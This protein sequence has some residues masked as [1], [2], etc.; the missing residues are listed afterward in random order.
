MAPEVLN[1]NY[2]KQADL[3]SIGVI[4]FM[5][6]SSQM[7]FYGETRREITKQIKKGKYDFKGR[8]WKQVSNQAKEF[9]QDLL[10]LDPNERLTADQAFRSPWLNS[11]HAATVRNP[12]Q[13]ELDSAQGAIMNYAKYSKLKKVALMLVAHKSTSE[14]IGILRKIFQQYDTERNGHLSFD[15][16]S[17]ALRDAGYPQDEIRQVFD[18]LVRCGIVCGN[19]VLP[20]QSLT[21]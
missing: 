12:L 8:R 7:P 3:W 20:T 9:V 19:S 15:E 10:V 2:T 17:H 6:L 11:R 4:T 5:L 14:E 21:F 18:S 1:Q 16:F 13:E